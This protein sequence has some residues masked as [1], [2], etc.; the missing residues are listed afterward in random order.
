MRR[1]GKRASDL[2]APYGTCPGCG[3]SGQDWGFHY[4]RY[5]TK[6]HNKW[7][8]AQAEV[9]RRERPPKPPNENIEVAEGV[10]ITSNVRKHLNKRAHRDVPRTGRELFWGTGAVLGAFIWMVTGCAVMWSLCGHRQYTLFLGACMVGSIVMFYACEWIQNDEIRKRLSKVDTRVA[11]LARERQ[12]QIDESRAFYASPEWR[13]VRK[14]VVEEQGRVCQQCR[15]HIRDDYDLTVDHV[16]P[17]SKFPELGL[18][19]SNLQVLCRRCNSAK[20]ATFN[21]ASVTA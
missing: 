21:E 16:K 5:C 14:Q 3:W 13:L 8:K 10:I 15:S 11:E 9:R 4:H 19:K 20:G 7:R 18:D 6:C 1:R 2:Y 12:R 17:R